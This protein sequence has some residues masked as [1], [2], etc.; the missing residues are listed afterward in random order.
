MLSMMIPA[1][2]LDGANAAAAGALAALTTLRASDL[3]VD[4]L[5]SILRATAKPT[6]SPA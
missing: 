6:C 1:Y 3:I 4:S 2:I 5:T